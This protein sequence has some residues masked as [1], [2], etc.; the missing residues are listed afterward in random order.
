LIPIRL[1]F[2]LYSSSPRIII[3]TVGDKKV[4]GDVFLSNPEFKPGAVFDDTRLV[5]CSIHIVRDNLSVEWCKCNLVSQSKL[6]VKQGSV[7]S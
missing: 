1:I 2:G 7:S 4:G 3:S 6:L 5:L